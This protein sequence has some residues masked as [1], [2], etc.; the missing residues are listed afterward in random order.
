LVEK[1]TVPENLK[2]L[3]DSGAMDATAYDQLVLNPD[4]GGERWLYFRDAGFED[5]LLIS[6]EAFSNGGR[7]VRILV[8]GDSSARAVPVEELS[9]LLSGLEE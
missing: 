1:G 7:E 6:K 8:R 5:P 4:T 9:G 2:Q 3:L